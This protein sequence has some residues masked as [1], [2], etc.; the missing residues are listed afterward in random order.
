MFDEALQVGFDDFVANPV[1][2]AEHWFHR[3]ADF[4]SDG[5]AVRFGPIDFQLSLDRLHDVAQKTGFVDAR[6]G[7]HSGN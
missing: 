5:I 1:F 2:A 7:L 4:G 3:G 6:D